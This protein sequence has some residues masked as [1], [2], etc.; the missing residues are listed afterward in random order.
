MFYL[1]SQ[2]AGFNPLYYHAITLLLH[3][4]N[5]VLVFNLAEVLFH[6]KWTS[7]VSSLLFATYLMNY[8]V[9]YWITGIFYILLTVFYI[10]ALLFFMRYLNKPNERY[11]ALFVG[12][13]ACAV[14]TMEQGVTLLGV[15]IFCEIVRSGPSK[16]LQLSNWKQKSLFLANGLKK[17]ILPIVIVLIFLI[18]KKVMNQSF[19]VTTNTL[20]SFIKTIFGMIWHLFIPFP[21]GI[22]SDIFY[23]TSRWN[24]RMYLIVLFFL[25]TTGYWLVKKYRQQ[26]SFVNKADVAVNLFLFGCILSYVIPL[27]MATMIQARYFYVPSVFSS[28][29]LGNLFTKHLS[30]IT[31]AKNYMRLLLHLTIIAFIAA[32]LPINIRFLNNQYRNWEAASEIT[33]N[34]INDTKN[35]LSEK[36]EGQDLYYVNLPDGIY[37]Q[38]DFGWPDA[39]VFRNGIFQAIRLKYP[40]KKIGMVRECRTNNPDGVRTWP[41]HELMTIGQLYQLAANENNLV[42][43]Y[44]PHIRTIKRFTTSPS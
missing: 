5:V 41:F 37:D 31:R 7:M 42:L 20:G 44:D 43:V 11:Y 14:L 13:F 15:C 10:S 9:V 8:E 39:Y 16:I 33:R 6:N 35:Y 4:I 38:R 21:Y 17:Y 29:M 24:Y 19:V 22:N 28:I 25:G 30:N 12:A 34:I 26:I 1:G 23:N 36:S 32:S 27:S 18:I 40:T 3:I 2:L